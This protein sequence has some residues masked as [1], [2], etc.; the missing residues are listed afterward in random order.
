MRAQVFGSALGDAW[1]DRCRW[2]RMAAASGSLVMRRSWVRFPPAAP[3]FSP[4]QRPLFPSFR[5]IVQQWR[6]TVPCSTAARLWCPGGPYVL[7]NGYMEG[8]HAG[9]AAGQQPAVDGPGLE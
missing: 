3:T 4:G 6:G 8:P 1:C 7:Y 5:L 2:A 9:E